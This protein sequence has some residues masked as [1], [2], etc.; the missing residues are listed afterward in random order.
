MNVALDACTAP[1]TAGASTL[2]A[3]LVQE[4]RYYFVR[5]ADHLRNA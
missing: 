3:D 1:G 4:M 5:A 2:S